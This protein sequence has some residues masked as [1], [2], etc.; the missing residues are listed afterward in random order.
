MIVVALFVLTTGVA[1]L[2]SSLYVRYR[3]VAPIWGVI[4]QALFYASPVFI[5]IEAIQKHGQTVTRLLPV[6]PAGDDP[7]AGA[8]LD[9]RRQPAATPGELM[10]GYGWALVPLGILLVI[11]RARATGSSA[12]RRRGSP[13][14][15]ERRPGGGSSVPK[16]RVRRRHDRPPDALD[17]ILPAVAADLLQAGGGDPLAQ[18]ARP[19]PGGRGARR[20]GS[21]AAA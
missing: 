4:S 3:D 15:C 20:S 14:S 6:Q 9:D 16:R 5:I 13:R 10:G 18:L 2:L 8:P 21:A 7:P 12:A 19:R 11:V 1:M 17:L